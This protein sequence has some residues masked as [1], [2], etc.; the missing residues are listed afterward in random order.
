MHP[1]LADP[2]VAARV[3]AA[4]APYRALL[5]GEDLAFLRDELAERMNSD[6]ALALALRRA[7]PRHV[8]Q[9]GEAYIGRALQEPAETPAKTSARRGGRRA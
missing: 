2:W 1:L 5:S 4:V 7:R 9:S 3:D 6:E 8:E